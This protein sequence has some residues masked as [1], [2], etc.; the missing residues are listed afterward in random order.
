LNENVKSTLQEEINREIFGS[1]D[2]GKGIGENLEWEII[3]SI[4]NYR[5]LTLMTLT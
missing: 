3:I 1:Q 2:Q 5:S 4:P